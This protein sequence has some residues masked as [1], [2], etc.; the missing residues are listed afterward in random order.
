ML[1]QDIP[2]LTMEQFRRFAELIY[3]NACISLKDSKL[4]LL[5]NRLRKRLRALEMTDFDEYHAYLRKNADEM[6]RFLEVVTT[7]ES[8][9][10]RTTQN[11]DMLK[12]HL[13]PE[14]LNTFPDQTLNFWSA[15]CSTGEEPYNLA[16]ELIDGMKR[17]GVFPFRIFATDISERVVSFAQQGRYHGRKLERVPKAALNRYF[18]PDPDREEGFIVRSDIKERIEFRVHNLFQD[19]ASLPN[20]HCIFCRN[21]MIYF[22][23]ADQEKLVNRFHERLR[24]G[25]FLVI[26]HSESLHTMETPFKARRLSNGI[27]YYRPRGINSGGGA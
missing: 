25:G 16:M 3:Q 11:F 8:Y 21:V 10:W 17:T 9:F 20:M 12:E 15:G 22:K 13:L 24:P 27:A 7:N 2:D 26:G 1:F 18:T 14:M 4:T 6:F 5:S 19:D 23:R